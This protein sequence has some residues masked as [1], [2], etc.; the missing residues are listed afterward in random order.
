MSVL[1]TSSGGAAIA[2][3]LGITDFP[4]T[5][6]FWAYRSSWHNE[7]RY[8]AQLGGGGSQ[9]KPYITLSQYL[10]MEAQYNNGSPEF[11]PYTG[12]TL[13]PSTWTPVVYRVTASDLRELFK[14]ALAEKATDTSDIGGFDTTTWPVEKFEVGG[15]AGTDHFLGLMSHI[16]VWDKALTDAEVENF[17]N[18]DSP[19]TIA[20]AN[21]R[22]Y[23]AETFFQ[24]TD[25][26]YEDKSGNEYHL[27]LDANA[28]RDDSTAGPAINALPSTAIP[29]IVITDIKEPN[30]SD[31]LVGSGGT[32]VTNARVRV[33]VGSDDTAAA[34][35]E[36]T[37][38][39]ITDGEMT[40]TLNTNETINDPVIASVDWDAGSG[41]TKYFRTT[42]NIIDL[43]A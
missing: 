19:L 13:A 20:D 11:F 3:A 25:W 30:E 36:L 12:S 6:A 24:D 1:D 23:W 32:S 43:D 16:A 4:F 22:A 14:G 28:V 5:I 38:E 39:T 35:Y 34:K 33:W 29:G 42:G 37:D 26:Y 9:H 18:G 2:N 7:T 17:L 10:G 27:L 8:L 41:E 21:L 15:A 40:L 31:A